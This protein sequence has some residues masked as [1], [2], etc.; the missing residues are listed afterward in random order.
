M[1][2][3]SRNGECNLR[4]LCSPT[5]TDVALLAEMLKVLVLAMIIMQKRST[6]KSVEVQVAEGH[7]EVVF[8]Y[9]GSMIDSS[10][11]SSEVLRRPV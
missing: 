11:G 8:V 1:H 7:V 4:K 3:T 9:L 5:I 6:D 2:R 10:G